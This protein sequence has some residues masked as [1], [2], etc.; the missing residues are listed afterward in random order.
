MIVDVHNGVRSEFDDM[1]WL[2]KKDCNNYKPNFNIMEGIDSE[3]EEE[4]TVC[5]DFNVKRIANGEIVDLEEGQSDRFHVLY[6][7]VVAENISSDE[8]L[9]ECK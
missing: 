8:K 4:I 1:S 3:S 6:D 7:N 9:M 5:D 2:T